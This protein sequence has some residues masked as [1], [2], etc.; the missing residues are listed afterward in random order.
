MKYLKIYLL[1]LFSAI[2]L[3]AQS[4]QDHVKVSAKP[5]KVKVSAGET[6][7]VLVEMTIDKH[8]YTY[9]FVEQ[10]NKDGIGPGITTLGVEPTELF[11]TVEM[12]YV[13]KPDSKYDEG[14][15]FDIDY[16]KGTSKF[17]LPLT[18]K[19]DIDFSK[20]EVYA[21]FDL[22]LCDTVSCLPPE[23][24]KGRISSETAEIP[25]N[26]LHSMIQVGF[27]YE[28]DEYGTMTTTYLLGQESIETAYDEVKQDEQKTSVNT[29]NEEQEITDAKKKGLFSFIWFSMLMGGLALLTPCVFPMIPITVSFFTKRAEKEG[30]KGKG[31][32]DA[33]IYA[34]GII[35]TFTGIGVV[36]AALFGA[37]GISDLATNGWINLFIASVFIVFALNLFGAFEIM[38]PQGLVNKM[39]KKTQGRGLM[40]LLVMGFIFSLT[41]FTCTVP[42]V[43]TALISVSS[44]EW[45][46]PVLGMVGFSVV[47]AA[48][49]F[50]LA[51]FPSYMTKLPKSGGWLNN[52]KVVMGFIEIAAAI[53]FLS[54]ADL[55]WA[56]QLIPRE[57]FLAIW[58]ACG[59]LVVLYVMG[60]Y[61][62]PH[63]SEVKSVNSVRIMSSLF[64]LSVT[65]WLFMG[66]FGK[67]LGELDAFLPPKDYAS[68]KNY[69]SFGSSNTTEEVWFDNYDAALKEAKRENKLLFVD[70][71]GFQCTNCRWMESNMFPREDIRSLMDKMVKVKL[72]TDRKT[73]PYITNKQ[74]QQ[75]MFGSINLP[76]YAIMTP[77]EE[78]IETK[79]FTRDEIEF[80][81]FL[82][83]A[84][85]EF[86][87]KIAMQ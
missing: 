18:A 65:I 73:E 16:Y 72:Y 39:N 3:T 83:N 7:N 5:E 15:E 11:E 56:L 62:L 37:T 6:V 2:S 4:P 78:L 20:A 41:S 74:F 14:F 23:F 60:F 45:F 24:Y 52:V 84:L 48:P 12:A 8:W 79:A 27:R 44:G 82:Q 17:V 64:A 35:I 49:F 61:K 13:S 58:V 9:G 22:Q 19:K 1:I 77:D 29:T 75:D 46:Y 86:N 80:R 34:L 42:F 38:L 81:D 50:L 43:G 71:T 87:S 26:M 67:H 53:K 70:F 10:L 25:E 85:D 36:V 30:N 31:L 66:L 40:S 33:S 54:N 69:S 47:F 51:I 55:Y 59:I 21:V 68:S 76:L 57:V 63:D 28:T 32:L